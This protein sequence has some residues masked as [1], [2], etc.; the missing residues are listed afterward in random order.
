MASFPVAGCRPIAPSGWPVSQASS[1]LCECSR[2][3][4][5]GASSK[6]WKRPIAGASCASSANMSSS[7]MR[8]PLRSGLRQCAHASG[9]CM[10]N[11]RLRDPKQC[12]PICRGEEG[13][14]RPLS[15]R[16]HASRMLAPSCAPVRSVGAIKKRAHDCVM[17]AL[18]AD[19]FGRS[20]P[21][22]LPKTLLRSGDA[23]P[24]RR[25]SDWRSSK[26]TAY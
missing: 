15:S 14:G 1:Y 12:S 4:F 9:W 13:S 11:A 19:R 18:A 8:Q 10:P 23:Y 21:R 6:N 7:T 20:G 2:G 22:R 26:A 3:C 16:V 17:R 24:L 25:P 5:A